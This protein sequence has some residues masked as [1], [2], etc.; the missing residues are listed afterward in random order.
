[1][2]CITVKVEA[3]K[4]RLSMNHVIYFGDPD[5]DRHDLVGGKAVNLAQLVAAG[6]RV[7]GGFTISTLAYA[8]AL[9]QSGIGRSVCDLA[10]RL[11]FD[12]LEAVEK[13]SEKI[14]AMVVGIDLPQ[15]LA[16]E[17][18]TACAEFGDDVQWAVRSSGT[19][20]DTA[21]ASFA[22][23]HDTFLHISGA[24]RVIDAVRRC[25]ASMWS[26][27]ALSYRRN[28]GFDNHS[29]R[30]AVVIQKMVDAEV[31][32]VMFTANPLNARTDEM[33]VNASYGLGEAI[34]SGSV[35]PD[36]FIV[37][38]GT[39]KVKTARLGSKH[40][41]I[42]R[43]PDAPSG[44]VTVTIPEAD[45]A[46]ACLDDDQLAE[47]A[48]LGRAV[49][50]HYEGL[51]QDVE[52]AYC[53]GQFHLLQARPIT[54]VEF[55]WTEG[56]ND[57][58]TV[59]ERDDSLWTFKYAEQ[60]WTGGITPLFYSVRAREC[61]VGMV[62]TNERAGFEDL[63]DIRVFKYKHGTVYWNVDSDEARAR[64][65]LP[66]FARPGAATLVPPEMLE[67][68]LNEPLDVVRW[69]K[70][71]VSFNSSPI[72]AFHK[73]KKYVWEK[74]VFNEEAI[75][76]ATGLS[77]VALRRL[78]DDELWNYERSLQDLAIK[79]M[80]PLWVGAW[81]V[82]V[83]CSTLHASLVAKYYK[84]S[85]ALIWQELISGLPANLQSQEN[86]AF[87]ELTEHIR[88]SDLLMKTYKENEGAEFF[89][90][91]KN[92]EEGRSFLEQ[93]HEF[94]RNHGHR[95]HADRDLYFK[96]RAD[97]PRIDYE[98][99]RLHLQ[100]PDPVSP[101]EVEKRVVDKREL[102]VAE[103]MEHLGKGAFGPVK[104]KLFQLLQ[105]EVIQFLVLREDW[106][107]FIDRIS[108]AKRKAFLE[109]GRR[110]VE[111]GGLVDIDDCFFLGERELFETLKDTESKRLTQAKI[112]ARRAQFERMESR[113]FSPPTFLR[114]DT[115]I[116]DATAAVAG[117]GPEMVGIGT[118]GG[119][120]EGRARVLT[121]MSEI[122]SLQRGEILICN[123]TDPGW[124][125]VFT[126]ISGLVIET[127]GML[128]HGACLSREHGL[129]AVQIVGATQLIP[130]G[131]RIR[132]NGTTGN[133]T[134]LSETD[135][136]ASRDADATELEGEPA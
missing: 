83:M 58:Q 45:R 14:R 56:F 99:F 103:V 34:V 102:A 40:E 23:M 117:S 65:V 30:I 120:A 122:G 55:T 59:P 127:G 74:Y 81:T 78:S 90:E 39:L 53:D 27:R 86:H 11:D 112:A 128:A 134:I 2:T 80:D 133:V 82:A 123:A 110:C 26:A 66:R 43:D 95:G 107:H 64:Y 25:W 124:S 18:A 73:W 50:R 60:F 1:M 3:A 76:K 63:I 13:A 17:I 93:Y 44:T 22:G 37:D 130:D 108:Y 132:V 6:L 88:K 71:M 16:E 54:G 10:D 9:E 48:E 31:S 75:A 121:S 8:A 49:T 21:E 104:Q 41:K 119:V 118:S 115:P 24:E 131:A 57:W 52:W 85:N 113:T 61:H 68:T 42:I 92:S 126:I 28:N 77:E 89:A 72:L 114:G 91:L 15:R 4:G 111:R 51:P 20:E 135:D 69:L 84:G 97:E 32:G 29:A 96:R 101:A 109:V 106:R 116:E 7:P 79:F 46:R 129:P 5:G 100:V 38:A 98:A 12:N 19:A 70:A 87:Y 94:L 33:V 62:K 35:N 136:P 105:D 36:E 125:P 67:R 47:L